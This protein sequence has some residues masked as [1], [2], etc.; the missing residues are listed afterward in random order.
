VTLEDVLSELLGDVG[1]VPVQPERLPDGRLRVS[2]QLP[3]EE[4]QRWLGTEWV[5]EADT[6]AGHLMEVLGRLPAEGEHLTIDG[7]RIE[8]ERL[9]GRVPGTLLITPR[10]PST[11]APRG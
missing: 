4:A 8:V 10:P 6:M 11:E 5:S 2:G 1:D 7:I 3:L 9:H